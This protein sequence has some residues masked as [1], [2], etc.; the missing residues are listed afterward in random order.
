MKYYEWEC[1]YTSYSGAY[2]W[3]FAFILEWGSVGFRLV[4]GGGFL[5]LWGA[6]FI[7]FRFHPVIFNSLSVNSYDTCMSFLFFLYR[8]FL[9]LFL[10]SS[11]PSDDR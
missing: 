4:R 2:Y 10:S 9:L 5:L 7:D 3:R 6:E 11:Y 8:P 1:P